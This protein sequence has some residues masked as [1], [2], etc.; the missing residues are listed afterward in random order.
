MWI[1]YTRNIVQQVKMKFF[2]VT[3]PLGY[4]HPQGSEGSFVKINPAERIFLVLTRVYKSHGERDRRVNKLV[5]IGS[6]TVWVCLRRNFHFCISFQ[7]V[8]LCCISTN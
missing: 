1:S 4:D 8:D 7:P 6:G 5:R 3:L 2:Q